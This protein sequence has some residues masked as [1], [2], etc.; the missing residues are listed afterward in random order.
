MATFALP[1]AA[2]TTQ[3]ISTATYSMSQPV[4]GMFVQIQLENEPAIQKVKQLFQ[5]I[6]DLVYNNRVIIAGAV[7]G[8]SLVWWGVAGS[9][10]GK[11]V[12]FGAVVF[13]CVLMA[14]KTIVN[15]INNVFS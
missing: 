2:A 10:S 4:F 6:Y 9:R 1:A 11:P 5:Q 13:S 3:A 7:I 15:L 14:L 8:I 12:F